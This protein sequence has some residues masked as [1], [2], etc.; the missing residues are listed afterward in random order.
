MTER[1]TLAQRLTRDGLCA[2]CEGH[3]WDWGRYGTGK[4][5]PENIRDLFPCPT[6]KGT[7]LR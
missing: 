7:G 5:E 4:P 6:C 2:H 1:I 3:G